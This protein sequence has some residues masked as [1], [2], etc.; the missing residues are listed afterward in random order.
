MKQ[1]KIQNII[2]LSLAGNKFRVDFE[3]DNPEAQS[4]SRSSLPKTAAR[5]LHRNALLF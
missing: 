5:Y 2:T 1:Q 3:N 4:L